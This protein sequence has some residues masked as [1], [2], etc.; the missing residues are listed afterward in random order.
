MN[1]SYNGWPASPTLS[2]IVIEP[3]PGCRLRVLDNRNVADI[4]TYLVQQYHK[5]VDDVT[6]PH[7]ADDWGYNYR[8]NR[9]NP[10]E[11]SCHASAT[12]IDLD[13]TEHPNGVATAKTFTPRQIAEIH[14]ILEELE[15]V[16]RWGGDYT[17]TADAMH[18]EIIAKPGGVRA[19]GRK[20]RRGLVVPKL[21]SRGHNIDEAVKRLK[22]SKGRGLRGSLIKDA[23]ETLL[24]IPKIK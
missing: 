6:K 8:P 7:P 5:R 13:A 24:K 22:R 17:N 4:F 12:A 11:L 15:G 20:L 1:R 21:T 2:T 14:D 10:L 18:F 3:V 19:I 9:N 16:V 23:I